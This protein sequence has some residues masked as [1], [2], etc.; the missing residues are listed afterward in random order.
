MNQNMKQ[1]RLRYFLIGGLIIGLIGAL[2]GLAFKATVQGA[3]LGFLV[4]GW[5]FMEVSVWL[6]ATDHDKSNENEHIE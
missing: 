6:L 4:G 2:F 3:V 1:S 5:F